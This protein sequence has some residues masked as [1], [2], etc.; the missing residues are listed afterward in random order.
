M[1]SEQSLV[2]HLLGIINT[3]RMESKKTKQERLQSPSRRGSWDNYPLVLPGPRD[4]GSSEKKAPCR[5]VVEPHMITYFYNALEFG[6]ERLATLRVSFFNGHETFRIGWL[7]VPCIAGRGG[8]IK[9]CDRKLISVRI[10]HG[11]KALFGRS[12]FISANL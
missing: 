8:Q 9:I 7:I 6:S 1:E 10:S 4:H 11:C 5:L 3:I 2:R 12:I